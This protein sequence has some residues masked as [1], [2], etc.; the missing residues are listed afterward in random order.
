M[1]QKFIFTTCIIKLLNGKYIKP[2]IYQKLN[3]REVQL[4]EYENQYMLMDSPNF[5]FFDKININGKLEYMEIIN[6]NDKN[7]DIENLIFNGTRVFTKGELISTRPSRE[8]N[9]SIYRYSHNRFF[10]IVAVNEKIEKNS[11]YVNETKK[12]KYDLDEEKK[13]SKESLIKPMFYENKH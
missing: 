4:S 13:E 10:F 7:P 8:C 1:T 12:R 3:I 9:I 6:F 2:E 11:L 5:I